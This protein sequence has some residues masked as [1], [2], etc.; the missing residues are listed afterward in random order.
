MDCHLENTHWSLLGFFK[1]RSLDDWMEQLFKH[2]GMCVWNEDEYMFM[3]NARKQWPQGCADSGSTTKSGNPIYY[4]VKPVA[5]GSITLGL[6]TDS[7]CVEEYKSGWNDAATVENVLGN[8]LMQ[9]GSGSGDYDYDSSQYSLQDSMDL[10]DSSFD[11][12]KQC[13]PCVAYDL[14][15][16]GY[17]VDDDASRGSSYGTY[18]YG[19]DD[20]Y[21]FNYY[22]GG[23]AGDDFDCYDD[24]GY[25]NV[26]QVRASLGYLE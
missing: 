23:N 9:Q 26:N 1:H 14:N 2:E 19:Y 11:V 20:D 3:K 16:V 4:D 10:W 24:A 15:N 13:Q 12:F 8:I 7:R 22:Y 6:Y 25:T 17:N 5:G 18:R 21:S